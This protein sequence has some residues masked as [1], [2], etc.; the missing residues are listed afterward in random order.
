M[1]RLP[2]GMPATRSQVASMDAVAVIEECI[3]LGNLPVQ[4]DHSRNLRGAVIRVRL[5]V[6]D[7]TIERPIN[8][9]ALPGDIVSS[10]EELLEEARVYRNIYNAAYREGGGKSRRMK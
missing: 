2:E 5:Y 9:N 10:M 7:R 4:W 6:G 3:R 8:F 1:K